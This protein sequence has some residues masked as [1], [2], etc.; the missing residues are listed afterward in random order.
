MDWLMWFV[1]AVDVLSTADGAFGFIAFMA[2]FFWLLG[3]IAYIIAVASEGGSAAKKL[4]EPVGGILRKLFWVGV[5]AAT[6]NVVIPTTT[7]MYT[8]LAIK[9]VDVVIETEAVQTLV[10]KSVEVVET[11]LDTVIDDLQKKGQG[12]ATEQL[13]EMLD[14]RK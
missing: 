12:A 11:Y 4:F 3:I 9:A 8:M 10:P 1:Y 5:I 6:L 14:A 7:T 2:L 13:E